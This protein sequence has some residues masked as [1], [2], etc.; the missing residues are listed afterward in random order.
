MY[1]SDKNAMKNCI[2]HICAAAFSVWCLFKGV[3][4]IY[5]TTNRLIIVYP[6]AGTIL[7]S[8]AAGVKI[9]G[10]SASRKKCVTGEK[11]SLNTDRKIAEY[12]YPFYSPHV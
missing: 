8:A 5:G 2:G 1:I 3:P 12:G 6:I 7:I 9:A 4:D 10:R 11:Y